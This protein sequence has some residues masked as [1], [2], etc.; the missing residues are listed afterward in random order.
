MANNQTLT[1]GSL[2]QITEELILK[3]IELALQIGITHTAPL[4]AAGDTIILH[5]LSEYG[6]LNSR[7]R[8]SLISIR[9]YNSDVELL[10]TDKNGSFLFLGRYDIDLG[11]E[12]VAYEYNRIIK[13]LGD[14]IL[15]Q[16]TFPGFRIEVKRKQSLIQKIKN[17]GKKIYSSQK[18]G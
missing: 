2:D 6:K 11:V 13:M 7:G 9:K 1:V 10:V 14:R 17:Y 15:G 3:A 16:P 18:R 5:G 4:G 12:F 8:V